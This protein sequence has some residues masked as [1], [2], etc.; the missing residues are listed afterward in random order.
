MTWN[1]CPIC[2]KELH[3]ESMMTEHIRFFCTK[4]EPNQKRECYSLM[5]FI[6]PNSTGY[7]YE[8]VENYHCYDPIVERIKNY[9]FIGEIRF[10][11][12]LSLEKLKKLIIL[13]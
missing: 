11:F 1:D 7:S 3:R 2:G 4:W 9:T 13:L 10:D 12:V 5:C 8:F 6:R